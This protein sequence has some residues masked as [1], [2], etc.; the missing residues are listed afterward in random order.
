MR[1]REFITFIGGAAILPIASRAQPTTPVIG[2]LAVRT[3]EFDAPLVEAFKRGMRET[4]FVE[5]KN[6]EI[7]YRWAA[8]HFDR[9]PAL[10][11]ELVQKHVALIVTFGGTA[12]AR[13]AKAATANI[14]IVFGIGDDP[15]KFGLVA[16]LNRPRGKYH[17]RDKLLR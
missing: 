4:N 3:P 10:A 1:R 5:G 9:L 14:P 6:V 8:G 13:A 12:S 15:V 11:D 7:E 17:R 16:N 2:L